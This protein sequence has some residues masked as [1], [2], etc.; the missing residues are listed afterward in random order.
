MEVFGLGLRIQEEGAATVEAAVKKLNNEMARTTAVAN[1]NSQAMDV[2]GKSLTKM[3]LT[4]FDLGGKIASAGTLTGGLASKLISFGSSIAGMFGPA[5]IAVGALVAFAGAAKKNFTV[6]AEEAK[7]MA[8]EMNKQIAGMVNKGDVEAL[9]ERYRELERGVPYGDIEMVDGE[10]IVNVNDGLLKMKERYQWIITEG[11]PE[12]NKANREERDR[13]DKEIKETQRQI[14]LIQTAIQKYSGMRGG[15]GLPAV[16]ITGKAPEKVKESKDPFLDRI[17]TILEYARLVPIAERSTQAL[18]G[19]ESQLNEEMTKT[20]NSMERRVGLRRALNDVRLLLS[21]KSDIEAERERQALQIKYQLL[22]PESASRTA[23]LVAQRAKL[24]AE[25][26]NENTELKRKYDI[27]MM[28]REIEKEENKEAKA[29]IQKRDAARQSFKD[30]YEALYED[31]KEFS[32][33]TGELIRQD[34]GATIGGALQDGFAA[35]LTAAIQS[36]RIADLWKVMAQTMIAQLANMMVNVALHY[37][38]YA[39]MIAAIQKFLIA[40][41]VA[42]VAAAAAMLAF[43]YNNGGKG[44]VGDT[45]M[46][47]GAGGLTTGISSP[48]QQNNPVQQIIFGA[49]SASTAAGMNPRQAMNVTIIG[50]NDPQAQRALQEMMMKA[51]SRGRLG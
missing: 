6:A 10:E 43:A 50:P 25:L 49:T 36:G 35:G 45:V 7:K 19:I 26:E 31:S 51:D 41:P 16:E 24:V 30:Y 11:V 9:I 40:H 15:R 3:G 37:L 14:D 33:T 21:D 4:I 2:N 34:I 27:L 8:D 32:K 12:F 1:K 47:G 17:Q 18:Q 22:L 42:A 28:L 5:G 48:N 46:A 39:S 29:P 23:E 13:L 38:R 44:S 20:T